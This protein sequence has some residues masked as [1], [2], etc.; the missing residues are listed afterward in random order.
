VRVDGE[1]I[2]IAGKNEDHIC[3]LWPNAQDFLEPFPRRLVAATDERPRIAFVFFYYLTRN[4]A[5]ASRFGFVQPSLLDCA[6]YVVHV[7]QRDGLNGL[8]L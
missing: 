5:Y 6:L 4:R 3:C 2:K 7:C 1:D 8:I